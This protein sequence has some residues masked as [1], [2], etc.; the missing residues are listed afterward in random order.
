MDYAT[1][2]EGAMK[3]W[4][5]RRASLSKEEL[6]GIAYQDNF[7]HR[8]LG[9]LTKSY[10]QRKKLIA[11]SDLAL[12]Y[13]FQSHTYEDQGIE[14]NLATWVLFSPSLA[15]NKNP[16]ILSQIS[17]KL[18]SIKEKEPTDKNEKQLKNLLTEELSETSYFELPTSLTN[19]ELVYLSILDLHPGVV[20]AFHLGI[21][22]LL[23]GKRFSTEILYLPTKY[24]PKG[25]EEAYLKSE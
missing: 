24:A 17:A 3:E 25:F 15:V 16:A 13:V 19:G 4:E 23:I 7:R 9:F 20:Q 5:L 2:F 14:G 8:L 10:Y 22:L 1:W 18:A 12:G 6:A 21:N 11:N